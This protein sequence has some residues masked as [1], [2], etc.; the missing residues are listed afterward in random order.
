MRARHTLDHVA[1]ATP[2]PRRALLL[3]A[4][5]RPPGAHLLTVPSWESCGTVPPSTI[6]T[7]YG[8]ASAVL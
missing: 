6:T 5:F 1:A 4:R 8:S 2:S 7:W 3:D